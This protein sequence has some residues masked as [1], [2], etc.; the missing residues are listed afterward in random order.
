MAF[1]QEDFKKTSRKSSVAGGMA[2]VYPHQ[3]KDKKVL[4]RLE[5]AIRTFDAA[6]GKRRRDM[7]AQAMTDFFGDPRL[8]RGIVACLGSSTSTK[9]RTLGS[10]SGGTAR[11]GC[12]KPDSQSPPPCGRGPMRL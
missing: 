9:R 11:P 12:G 6:A 5:I 7:D 3:L 1:R 4:A 8:A 2:A 10:L